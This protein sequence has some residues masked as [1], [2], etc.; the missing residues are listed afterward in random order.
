MKR[1]GRKAWLK[2]GSFLVW[3]TKNVLR[4]SGKIAPPSNTV[5]HFSHLRNGDNNPDLVF[6]EADMRLERVPTH[7]TLF[8]DI[9]FTSRDI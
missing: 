5:K 1:A 3:C 9:C 4:K 7:S 6:S 2:I 8:V